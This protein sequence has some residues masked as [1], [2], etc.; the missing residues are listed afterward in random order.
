LPPLPRR[1][2]PPGYLLFVREGNL[3]AQPFDARRA[4]AE[5]EPTPVA[6]GV[7]T[8]GPTFFR[9]SSFSASDT[10]VLAYLPAG[11]TPQTRLVW[12]DRAGKV[13]DELS[14]PE[15]AQN[16]EISP[17]GGRVALDRRDPS[18]GARDIWLLDL[19]RSVAPRFTFDPADDSDSLWSPDGSRILFT[20]NR[21]ATARFYEKPSTGAGKETP[22]LQGPVGAGYTMSWS[23]DGRTVMSMAAGGLWTVAVAG[24]SKPTPFASGDF[25]EIE[26]QFSP[27]GRFVSYTSDESGRNEVYVQPFSPSG[28]KWQ[29]ST[30]G[31]SDARW[32]P[33]GKELFFLSPERNL[34]AVEL[35]S[36]ASFE[37]GQP[38]ELFQTRIAG[39]LGTGLRFN[40][41]VAPPDGRRFLMVLADEE[42]SAT[43]F[44]V[45]L[46]WTAD[47]KK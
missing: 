35:R 17:D 36:G 16:P 46:N 43:P 11:G 15:G 23:P 5:G 8:E 9:R 24:D 44:T 29:I 19:V 21:E 27:D 10:G 18:S 47:L 3:F 6:Y 39:P 14:A 33:D 34:M 26:G 12:L 7:S 25:S 40:Y 13:L 30:E 4:C 2:A 37:A 41:A 45:V 22:V 32:R 38:R 31:G 1:Y 28:G 20:S 42:S